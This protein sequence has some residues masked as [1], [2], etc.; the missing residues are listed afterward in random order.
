[1]WDFT[2]TNFL[3]IHNLHFFF[4]QNSTPISFFLY[5]LAVPLS[6]SSSSNYFNIFQDKLK[7]NELRCCSPLDLVVG[8]LT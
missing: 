3:Y 1:M 6:P 2:K 5:S 8:K 7:G 4:Y